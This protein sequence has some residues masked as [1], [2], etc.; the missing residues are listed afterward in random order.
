MRTFATT[1][2]HAEPAAVH[3]CA[4]RPTGRLLRPHSARFWKPKARKLEA[5]T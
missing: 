5:L 3:A 4:D 2:T 1:R